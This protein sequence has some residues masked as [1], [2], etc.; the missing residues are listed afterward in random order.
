MQIEEH[1]NYHRKMQK[2]TSGRKKGI[3]PPMTGVDH[4]RPNRGPRFQNYTPLTVPRGRVL[5]EAL[6]AKLIPVPKPTQTPRHADTTKR[7]QYPRNFG[8]L[9]EGCQTLKDKIEELVQAGHLHKFVKPSA[10]TT[11]SPQRDTDYSSRDRERSGRK[12]TKNRDID[13]RTTRRKHSES[14]GTRPRIESP[15]RD[16]QIKQRVRE[17]INT[18][19]GPVSLGAPSQEVNYIAGGFAGGGCSNSARK[20]HL[21]AIQ[22]VHSTLTRK[23]PHIPPITFTD[24]DFT[25]SDPAQDDPMVITVDI[26]KFVI[27]KVLVD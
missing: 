12:D 24:D 8:H 23:R 19:V 14:S 22:Y 5:D 27:V 13:C 11:R 16:E 18:I 1:I 10:A 26:D 9:T 6:Q 4:Y 15:E 20:K 21:R 3:R 17:V 7:C 2:E 25:A